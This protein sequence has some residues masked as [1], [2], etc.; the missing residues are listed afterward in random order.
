MR[1]DF[2][3]HLTRIR[4]ARN[5]ERLFHGSTLAVLSDSDT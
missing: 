1:V 5:K 4:A 3:R 2:S